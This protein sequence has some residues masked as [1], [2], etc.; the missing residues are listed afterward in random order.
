MLKK[1]T[2]RC[3]NNKIIPIQNQHSSNFFKYNQK[4]QKMIKKSKIFY[5]KMNLMTV[6]SNLLGFE[7]TIY[8]KIEKLQYDFLF[9][10][11]SINI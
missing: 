1:F 8:E 3:F 6:V 9:I 5:N 4:S 10:N 11:L 2:R 7:I